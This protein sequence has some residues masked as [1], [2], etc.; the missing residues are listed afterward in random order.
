MA[1]PSA[2]SDQRDHPLDPIP[3]PEPISPSLEEPDP[4]V[5]QHD[6]AP[7]AN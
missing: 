7:P 6:P 3:D 5:Y 1:L 4:G 2:S